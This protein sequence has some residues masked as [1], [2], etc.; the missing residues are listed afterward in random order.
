[1]SKALQAAPVSG[2][3]SLPWE[4]GVAHHHPDFLKT[5][6]W[7]YERARKSGSQLKSFHRFS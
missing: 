5:P 6:V 3:L 7:Q 4:T 2:T 1:M